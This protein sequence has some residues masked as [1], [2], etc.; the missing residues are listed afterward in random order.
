MYKVHIWVKK[1]EASK[2]FNVHEG[3]KMS[4]ADARILFP[5]KN[6]RLVKKVP[7][8]YF[9]NVEI[10]LS[11]TYPTAY[12][13]VGWAYKNTSPYSKI[14]MSAVPRNTYILKYK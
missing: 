7:F 14:H 4:H 12:G 3:G 1:A 5:P 8:C 11:G 6:G 9:L 2:F 13:D 10:Q